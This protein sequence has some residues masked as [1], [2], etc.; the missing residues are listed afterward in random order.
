MEEITG[1]MKINPED[2]MWLH[3]TDIKFLDKPH[4]YF[5][6]DR[7]SRAVK[8]GLAADVSDRLKSLQTG[9]P[10]KLEII[11]ALRIPSTKIE[12]QIH[13]LLKAYKISGEWF[14]LEYQGKYP[15]PYSILSEIYDCY[16]C[17]MRSELFDRI[18]R[19]VE[20]QEVS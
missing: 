13:N 16:V 17:G 9:N 10:N 18:F 15:S 2:G 20:F 5:I 7:K 6:L 19:E 3:M 12:K 11:A 8:I 14:S 1:E 4:L